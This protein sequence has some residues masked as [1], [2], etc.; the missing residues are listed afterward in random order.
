MKKIIPIVLLIAWA[1]VTGFLFSDR[2]NLKA[3]IA[4]LESRIDA[5]ESQLLQAQDKA[6]EENSRA[7]QMEAEITAALN[8]L[9]QIEEDALTAQTSLTDSL[10]Q[11]DSQIAEQNTLIDRLTE[12]TES[13]D[14]SARE[15]AEQIEELTAAQSLRETEIQTIQTE[16]EDWMSKATSFQIENQ[17]LTADITAE[18]QRCLQMTEELEAEKVSNTAALSLLTAKNNKWGEFMEHLQVELT[19]TGQRLAQA[20]SLI[21]R[22]Q[23]EIDALKAATQEA[24]NEI[25]SFQPAAQGKV[26]QLLRPKALTQT[27]E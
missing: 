18:K 10:A 7:I 14:I 1:I 2:N 3:H 25:I 16:K 15:K 8:K 19:D 13:Q 21:T 27:W 20:Q 26:L 17:A 9:S 11:R 22:Q 23:D 4:L 12:K 24:Q 5:T 6:Q